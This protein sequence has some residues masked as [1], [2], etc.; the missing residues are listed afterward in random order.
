MF[1]QLFKSK[2]AATTTVAREMENP[3]SLNEALIYPSLN[4]KEQ[5]FERDLDRLRMDYKAGKIPKINAAERKILEFCHERDMKEFL[6]EEFEKHPIV[7]DEDGG[8]VGRNPFEVEREAQAQ[9]QLQ[10][11]KNDSEY[12]I[13]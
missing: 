2:K 13:L 6:R 7:L 10:A 5:Q 8:L 9:M 11:T 4:Y 12:E 1:G 3:D